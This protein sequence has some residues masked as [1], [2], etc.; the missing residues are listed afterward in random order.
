MPQRAPRCC[1]ALRKL[2]AEGGAKIR[3]EVGGGLHS[4]EHYLI[5]LLGEEIGGRFH[6]AR[7]SGDL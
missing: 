7:S 4:G 6:L 3:S 1:K 5:R 2:E